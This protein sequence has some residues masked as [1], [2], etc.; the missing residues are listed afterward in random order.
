MELHD[1]GPADQTQTQRA[2]GQA[3]G[4][5]EIGPRL[6][7]RAGLV[8]PAVEMGALHGQ[9]VVGPL[10]LDVDERALALAEEQV[11]ER[12]ERQQRLFGIHQSGSWS[13]T[14]AGRLSRS[15]STS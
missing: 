14:P 4:D 15:T 10:T 5:A 1:V 8:D 6:V 3:P 11:L 9:C 7:P 12:R 13:T 2:Q